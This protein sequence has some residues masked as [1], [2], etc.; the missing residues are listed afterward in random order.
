MVSSRMFFKLNVPDHVENN[1]PT[2]RPTTEPS[3]SGGRATRAPLA[4]ERSEARPS[5]NFPSLP[6]QW[7]QQLIRKELLETLKARGAVRR[8]FRDEHYDVDT[9]S[10]AKSNGSLDETPM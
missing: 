5:S 6:P 1:A 3:V 4:A 9:A 2:V 8:V 7:M 10:S